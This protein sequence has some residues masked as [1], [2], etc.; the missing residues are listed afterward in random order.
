M[1]APAE[2]ALLR[3]R[4]I[5]FPMQKV[6]CADLRRIAVNTTMTS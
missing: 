6:V 1:I 2:F 5:G 4:R 3:N